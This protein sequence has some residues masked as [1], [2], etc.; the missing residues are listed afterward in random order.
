MKIAYISADF[1]IPI[2]GNKGGSVH[3]R[4][5]VS[6]FT[7][8]G[9]EVTIFS[10]D[11]NNDVEQKTDLKIVTIGK[12]NDFE[13]ILRKIRS[14]EKQ[15]SLRTNASNDMRKYF[16]NLTLFDSLLPIFNKE[17]FDLVYERYSIFSYSGLAIARRYNL[18]H[19]LEVNAPLCEEH[20]KMIG[21]TLKDLAYNLETEVFRKTDKI[22]VVSE[23]LKSFAERLG[24]P[25]EKIIVLPNAVNIKDFE[26][27]ANSRDEIRSRLN[28]Y[29][30]TVIG[31]VGNVRPWHSIGKLIKSFD[32]AREQSESLHLLIVGESYKASEIH[33]LI[34][35]SKYSESITCTGF[36]SHQEIPS[37][38]NAM[39][40]TVA[41]YEYTDSFY[42]SPLKI[43]EYMSC[44]KPVIAAALGQI[45][46]MIEDGKNGMLYKA[47]DVESLSKAISFLVT[48]DNIRYELGNSG[49]KWVKKNRSLDYQAGQVINLIKK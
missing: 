21:F 29:N 47:G 40:I 33:N 19:F 36:I 24:V 20:E 43:L 49:F 7:R 9:H 44:K 25:G 16:Y 34:S 31:F 46:E 42:F 12:F 35:K 3:I 48:H 10:P 1:G 30:K 38:I 28:L 14:A 45:K 26:I 23:Y 32:R 4:E 8:L 27:D 37:Y 18:P 6:A 11:T 41:P 5:T 39:D 13:S 22:I 17:K 2:L 15:I